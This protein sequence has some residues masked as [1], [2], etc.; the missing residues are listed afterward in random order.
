MLMPSTVI[1]ATIIH[2]LV[3][4]FWAG[5][6]FTLARLAGLGGEKFV[7]PQLGAAAIAVLTGGYLGYA[8]HASSFG[9]AEQVLAIGIACAVIAAVLQGTIGVGTLRLLQSNGLDIELAR[10]RIGKAQRVAA[11]LLAV[12]VIAMVLARYV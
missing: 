12:T 6:T 9:V 5:T 1:A 8:L 10:D 11:A 3:S 2:V 7:F 4:V